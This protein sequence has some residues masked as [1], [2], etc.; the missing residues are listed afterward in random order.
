MTYFR[1]NHRTVRPAFSEIVYRDLWPRTDFVV[2]GARGHLEYEFHLHP[3]ARPEAIRLAY[4]GARDLSVT[5]GGDL[6]IRTQI[7]TLTDSRPS[8]YQLSSHGRTPVAS[9][10][11]L[12]GAGT[13]GFSVGPHDADTPL[14]IDPDLAYSTF[15]GGTSGRDQVGGVQVDAQGN[16]YVAGT[17]FSSDFPTTP[18][19]Y[20]SSL[21]GGGDAFV[22]KLNADGSGVAWSTFLGGSTSGEG[23][24]A[25][26]IADDGTVVVLGR[27]DAP[28]FPTTPG[29]YNRTRSGPDDAFVTKLSADGS[30]LV[31]STLLG[32]NFTD[33]PS[34]L[35]LD[36]AG[37]PV[38]SGTTASVDFPTTAGAY[39]RTLDGTNYDAFVTKLSADG[40]SLVY[41]TF[42]GGDGGD[43][44]RGLEL[45]ADGNAYF[46]GFTDSN[47]YPTTPGAYLRT[48][49]G[50]TF[51]VFVTKLSAD[52]SALA[53]STLLGDTQTANFVFGIALDRQD[54]AYVT[55]HGSP[56][57]PVTAGVPADGDG[58]VTELNQTGSALVYSRR[59]RADGQ[60]IAV[61][62]AGNAFVSGYTRDSGFPTTPDAY[63]RTFNGSVED[64][65]LM[66]L[67]PAGQT[68]YSTVLGGSSQSFAFE[69]GF[70]IALDDTGG[71]Y[72]VGF[73]EEADFPTTPGA[74]D[75]TFGPSS[76]G[77]VVK[78]QAPSGAPVSTPGCKF[79][80]AGRITAANGDTAEFHGRVHVAALGAR[81]SVFYV[82]R[83]P[84][85]PFKLM[86]SQIAALVCSNGGESA[87]VFGS[88]TVA[89]STL[90]F[91]IDVIDAGAAGHTDSFRIRLSN[92]YDSGEKRLERGSLQIRSG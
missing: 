33:A 74:F 2:K 11:E 16:T 36:A 35:A 76:D 53:Y 60:A 61:D 7:G 17:T 6:G 80:G 49:S 64:A 47:N 39:D 59:I 43:N 51:D 22:A 8:T 67:D 42:V 32:G 85:Q 18:G 27:T 69:R 92:G 1:G 41:S 37:R 3:G 87:S 62:G 88:A 29:A 31:Y 55:G 21:R 89:G 14:V 30:R 26:A 54:D 57:F 23:A 70:D 91:R 65:F 78:F 9:R 4:R 20:S 15:L 28:D 84:A 68:L 45:D 52:G 19:A 12:L 46:T 81:G 75:R 58:F 56:S 38:V 82:D 63:D 34:G 90:D 13:Y 48:R 5:K 40:S 66:E 25:P 86:S 77:F 73:T 71:V 83:G 72:L 10:F 79:S 50:G 24:G 44:V